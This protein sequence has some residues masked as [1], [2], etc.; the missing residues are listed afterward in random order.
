ML[1]SVWSD[2]MT[3]LIEMHADRRADKMAFILCSRLGLLKAMG[4]VEVV[5][6]NP[7]RTNS[8]FQPAL[9]SEL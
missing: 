8:L 5:R 6:I 9:R 7:Q 2:A 1:S 4:R 3:Y